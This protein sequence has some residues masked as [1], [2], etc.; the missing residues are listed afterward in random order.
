MKTVACILAVAFSTLIQA[1]EPLKGFYYAESQSPTGKE[2]EN[3]ELLA[4]NKEQ[5]RAWFFT[6]DGIEEARRVLPEFSRYYRSLD[7]TW[8]FHWVGNPDER[9]AEFYQPSYD[10]S[11]WDDVTVPMQ[12]NV[13]GIQKDGG[14]KYGTP[15]Y[16][17]QPVIFKHTVAVDDWKGGVMRTPPADWTT[18]KDRNEVG[19]YRRAF[20]VPEDWK[21]R[22]TYINFDGVSSFFY[23][24]IN[25]KYV[26][27]SK[28]SRNTASF[29]ITP[30]LNAK[31]ENIVAVEVYR[32]SDGSFLEAQDMF[33]L[34]GIFRTVSLT[35]TAKVQVR[36]FRVFPDLD[37]E[38]K[39]GTLRVEADL[40]NL[41]RKKAKGYTLSYSLYANRL[42]SDENSPVEGVTG[43]V[44]VEE[45][46]KGDSTSAVVTIPVSNPKKWSA[47]S[48][49]RYTLVGQLKDGKGR[50]VETFSTSIGF[51]KVEIKDTPADEDEFGLAGRYYYINGKTVKL[52]GVNRQE[53]NPASG[54]AIT[55]KQMEEEIMLMKRGNINHVRNSHYSCTPY[56]YYLCDKY[57]I[58]L[59]DE[60]NLESHE[61]YYGK[62]SLSHVPEFEAAHVARVMELAHAHVN[63]PSVVIW[64]LGNEAGPGKN[65]VSAYNA[66]HAFDPSRPVQY[67]RNNSI[68]DMGSNQYP[69]IEWMRGAVTGKYPIKYP[70]HVSEYAHSMGNAGGNLVDYWNAIEST[71]FFCGAAIWDWVDQALFY[72]D[73]QTGERFWG[74]GGDFG[75]K[76]NNGMFCMN[77]ILFPDHSPKPEFYEVR[78]VYQNVGVKALDMKRGKI[79]VFN[80]HYFTPLSHYRMVWSL[81]KDGEK[82]RESDAFTA[83]RNIVGPRQKAVYGIPYRYEE[84]EA[85]SEYFVKIQF[86]LMKD[87]PWAKA[88]FVQMEEQLLVKEAG[89][90]PAMSTLTASLPCPEVSENNGFTTVTGDGFKVVFNNQEGTIHSLEYDG[91]GMTLNGGGPRIDAL[92]AP[93]DNDNWAYPAWFENGLHNLKHKATAYKR[94]NAAGKKG[95]SNTVQ[96]MYTVESQAPNGAALKGGTSGRYTVKEWSDR[97]FGP[98]D[99]KFVTTQ[100][101]TVY[102]DGSIELQS[103]ITSNKEKLVLA[104]LGYSMRLPRELS[105]Y[106]YYGRGPW[107]NYSDRRSGAFIEKYRSTVDEQFV[108]FP[109]P[110]SM[111]NR[112][113]VRWCALTDPEGNGVAF[114]AGDRMSASALPWSAMEMT[115]A[116]HPYQLPKPSATHLHLDVAVTGLGGNSCG[117][118]GPLEPDRVKAGNHS[119]SLI[120][121]PVRKGAFTETAAVSPSGEVP[122]SILRD[123]TGM[124]SVNTRKAN[125][126]IVYVLN[127]DG[128]DRPYKE[129]FNLREGGTVTAYYKRNP[130]VSV[131]VEFDKMESIPLTV[132]YASSEETG[133]GD[134]SHLT[135][136][137]LTTM[138]HTM[139]SVTVA[140]YPHWVDFD[141]GETKS[142]KGI[143]YTPRQDGGTNGDIKDFTLQVSDDGKNWGEPVLKGSFRKGKAPQRVMLDKPV[144][145]RYLRFTGL[146]SQNG[147]DFAG[148]AEFSVIAD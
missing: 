63:H 135:D 109:K 64:S 38:Y 129:P 113:D 10:V 5:P 27:F 78:K 143:V 73:R 107:N 101:W 44:K 102:S 137:D 139:Y 71:N 2:W 28:N 47:E 141:A 32:N 110:Q 118:G 37:A 65:F 18:Y 126:E 3:P 77:G 17:N 42:Y 24:W 20:T 66:L 34:P 133:E 136:G 91:K 40:R 82:I 124:V 131:T 25:G 76:P 72:Y 21:D 145:G 75:D 33:R 146:S 93:V 144:K 13:A 50:T 142:F 58:Y 56:W 125:A 30:Y 134:A 62:E 29:N 86:Q 95:E 55:G 9:P 112:E 130:E 121:R 26:G 22:E 90:H 7:G 11:G 12:W 85:G 122:L 114:I 81:Y 120:I 49:N 1:S 46:E 99:F 51:C 140:Q 31:G 147:A 115:L 41:S 39:D 36:D 74:Y 108:R 45:L 52:K 4:L 148:G 15:I 60:A 87:M 138:W 119:M 84:L 80:K 6:F 14:L 35:S 127:E 132:T 57:G 92:R 61:Y 106:T 67:E 19:S 128:K 117:Q 68:V 89:E 53:I 48:P 97:P 123:R 8:K 116:P 43:T 79:E 104:R 54:N 83:P 94:L 59:E 100:I 103:N 105:Q 23:L 111:G 69:S 98:D 88:G 96:L 16:A 70:F